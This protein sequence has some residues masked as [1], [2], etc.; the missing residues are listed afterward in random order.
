MT[1]HSDDL[2]IAANYERDGLLE[3]IGR[4]L[5]AMG[6]TPEDVDLH[7]LGAVDEFHVGGRSA[8]EKIVEH[9][10]VSSSK[11]VLDIGCGLGG[12]AR[13]ICDATG[14]RVDGVDLT[15]SYIE[16]GNRLSEWVS[17]EDAVT[18]THGSALDLPYESQHFDAAY[19]IHVGMNIEDK[20]TLM[21]EAWRV[22]KPGGRF[23]IYDVMLP[24]P[25]A[26]DYPL[27]WAEQETSSFLQS[28]GEYVRT[29]AE[30]GF[31]RC[32]A[33]D[34][35]DFAIEFFA[36]MTASRSSGPAPLGLHLLLGDTAS[37]KLQNI[38]RQ[39]HMRRLSPT[40]VIGHKH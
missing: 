14:C 19:M 16:A 17:M 33:E 8:T 31:V 20:Y 7:V 24:K 5:H 9:L 1:Q 4:A 28:S 38:A 15:A 35:T 36:Q 21:K 34:L 25:A 37:Q 3:K 40:L 30:A 22:L 23:V 6:R 26:I 32:E 10:R 11:R 2:K 27:P 13:F 18:L 12:P 39:V 29:L